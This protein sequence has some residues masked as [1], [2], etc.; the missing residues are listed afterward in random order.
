LST[1]SKQIKSKVSTW[2]ETDWLIS[3]F[4][5]CRKVAAGN[6]QDFVKKI[7]IAEVEN[8]AGDLVSGFILNSSDFVNWTKK[9]FLA[10]RSEKRE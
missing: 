10:K 9:T 5:R 1:P 8:P 2:L 4:G 6:Y 7:N 3:L